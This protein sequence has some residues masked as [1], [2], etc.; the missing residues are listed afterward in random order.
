LAQGD[1]RGLIAALA[2]FIVG[3]PGQENSAAPAA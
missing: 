2:V 1:A 3:I